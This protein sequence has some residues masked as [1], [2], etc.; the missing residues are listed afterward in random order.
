VMKQAARRSCSSLFFGAVTSTRPSKRQFASVVLLSSKQDFANTRSSAFLPSLSLKKPHKRFS[1]IS[2]GDSPSR[3]YANYPLHN[4]FGLPALSPTMSQGNLASWKK[5]VGDKVKEGDVIAEVETDKA[6]MEWVATEDGYVAKLLIPEGA[7]DVPVNAPALVTVENEADVAK[8]ADYSAEPQE[9][10]QQ[11]PQPQPQP[12]PQAAAPSSRPAAATAT[13][14]RVA[15]SPF[16]RK[17]AAETGVDLSGVKGT[18][19]EGRI[20]AADVREAQATARPVEQV[21]KARAEKAPVAG[22]LY[23]DYPNSNVRKVIAKRLAESKQ[24]IPHYYL[25]TECRVD[26]LLQI[27]EELNNR[28]DGKYKLSVNDFI[29]KASA[30]ALKKQPVVNSS[31][32]EQAIR[33]YHNVD[34][35]VAV[36]TPEGLFTPV[37]PDVDKKGLVAISSAVKELATKAK[38]KKLTP[39]DYE[40]GTFTISNLGM[41]GVKQFAAVINPPQAAILAVGATEKRLVVNEDQAAKKTKPYEEASILTVTLSCDHRVIDGAVGAEWLQA[42][43]SYMEDPLKML[44]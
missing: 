14:G 19:P 37:V 23:T 21:A 4:T 41:F 24:T 17:V 26:K 43:K 13:G 34:I 16:A 29:I 32:A 22:E 7:K 35:N 6:T 18:G 3:L 28:A 20:I 38:E 1:P 9:K 44:L 39:A 40:G 5:K 11:Q 10:K 27:R 42:F 31:W 33:R 36:S 15:A 25:T 12:Q 30:L 8:F 2:F